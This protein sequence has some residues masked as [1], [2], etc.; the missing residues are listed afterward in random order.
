M[1]E[2]HPGRNMPGPACASHIS[3]RSPRPPRRA[4]QYSSPR[5]WG[6]SELSKALSGD[7]PPEC[8]QPGPCQASAKQHS[9]K[10]E[11][12]PILGRKPGF[13][14]DNNLCSV[15]CVLSLSHCSPSHL[16][17]TVSAPVK[18]TLIFESM[19]SS[20][21]FFFTFIYID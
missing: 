20:F 2:S 1:R 14:L 10:L 19:L 9:H 4:I 6:T 15:Y 5:T 18:N 11:C 7:R 12:G 13:K 8:S 21:A 17:N 3:S 16:F